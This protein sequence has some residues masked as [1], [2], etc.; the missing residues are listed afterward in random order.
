M[1]QH[2]FGDGDIVVEGEKVD[3]ARGGVG[4]RRQALRKD[5]ARLGLNGLDESRHDVVEHAHL[6][7]GIA[8]SRPDKEVGQAGQYLDATSMAAGGE[9]GFKLVDQRKGSAHTMRH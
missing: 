7:V 8:L 6:F 5:H 1:L 3:D 9:G 2:R 4:D